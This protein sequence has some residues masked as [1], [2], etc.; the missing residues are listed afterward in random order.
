K[1]RHSG[2]DE[3]SGH[4]LP[5]A[6]RPSRGHP[7]SP[8]PGRDAWDSESSNSESSSS[9]SI[10]SPE[11]AAGSCTSSR[12]ATGPYSP[13]GATDSSELAGQENLVS[14]LQ[15]NRI[16]KQAHFQSLQCRGHLRDT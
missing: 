3:E 11:H 12:C 16:L 1:R 6:K 8:E 13:L 10:S 4:L 5:Q 15:I 9:S 2:G 14:Y 7:L